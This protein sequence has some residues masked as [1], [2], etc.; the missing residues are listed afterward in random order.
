MDGSRPIDETLL[1]AQR[2]WMRRLARELV[3]DVHRAE[4]IVQETWRV[5]IERPPR[6]SQLPRLRRWL[7][8]VLLN[9]VRRERQ[10]DAAARWHE[11]RAG[12][13]VHSDAVDLDARLELEER[14][15]VAL[16]ALEE[17][18]REAVVLRYIDGLSV[19]QIARR[20]DVSR[21]NVRQR[22]SRG[23]AK[24]RERLDRSG[25]CGREWRSVWIGWLCGEPGTGTPVS[26]LEVTW[27]ASKTKVVVA[28]I[29]GL[30]A[31]SW[32]V[33]SPSEPSREQ[34]VTVASVVDGEALERKEPAPEREPAESLATRE[35][36]ELDTW[37]VDR[38]RD[39]HGVVIDGDGVPVA[40]AA[41]RVHRSYSSVPIVLRIWR[42]R[43]VQPILGTT[44]SDREGRFAIPLAAG[45]LHDLEAES[46]GFAR[47]WSL[48][49]QAGER[50]VIQL[51]EGATL[52]GRV[53]L[54]SDGT[55]VAGALVRIGP[56]DPY[57]A[58][59]RFAV[60]TART[61]ADGTFRLEALAPIPMA[62]SVETDAGAV[63]V[64]VSVKLRD[65]QVT[66]VEVPVQPGRSVRGRVTDAE[67]GLVIAGAEVAVQLPGM[68]EAVCRTAEDGTYSLEVVPTRAVVSIQGGRVPILRISSPGWITNERPLDLLP[69]DRP[70]ETIDIELERGY[71]L[72]GRI[73]DR[74]RNAVEDAEVTVATLA[75]RR[76][77]ALGIFQR[78]SVRSDA[79]G[80]FEVDGLRRDL[81]LHHSRQPEGNALH[82][83]AAGYAATVIELPLARKGEGLVD[84]GDIVL[85]SP[86]AVRGLVV[87]DRG[88]PI[89]GADVGVV[90]HGNDRQRA[91]SGDSPSPAVDSYFARYR[92]VADDLGRFTVMGLPPGEIVVT[93]RRL[94]IHRRT[95]E[96]ITLAEGE[97]RDGLRL[98]LPGG[99]S[100]RGSVQ[101]LDGEPVSGATVYIRGGG[102]GASVK[103]N[104]D[105]EFEGVGLLPGKYTVMAGLIPIAGQPRAYLNDG[106]KEISA[107]T[108]GV[109][110][111]LRQ[112]VEAAG[113][114]FGAGDAPMAST[115]MA[116]TSNEYWR[117][118]SCY[119]DS[120]GLFRVALPEG[121]SFD[122]VATSR[123]N[124]EVTELPLK[125]VVRGGEEDLVLR[126]Q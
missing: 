57:E 88:T 15:S 76:S 77:G 19:S 70:T 26:T 46:S 63:P 104:A 52:E 64:G 110:L 34:G 2:R 41:I 4:D 48:G 95:V 115:E 30:C 61:G 12:V 106:V 107:G 7:R 105:G 11:E 103:T 65:N 25:S 94:G 8:V 49:H 40:G 32:V 101:T 92:V 108:E 69:S 21:E 120:E 122:V 35:P 121:V 62:L 31:L 80:L 81:R 54:E 66:T 112:A 29:V 36:V 14:L 43:E 71:A 3:S 116:F 27:M 68:A 55:G 59:P 42:D 33:L 89:A 58:G 17:P 125:S 126:V 87:D 6:S 23:I 109:A 75:Y 85:S 16:R 60:A 56:Q 123:A 79:E 10:V 84:V 22:L 73:V 90:F 9:V 91:R 113:V 13:E 96:T 39:L 24:L 100:I 37:V 82:A 20:Q 47:Y 72:R 53:V 28:G 5:A 45:R 51:Q 44:E 93:A 117:D 83:V 67:T 1:L 98:V 74:A 118:I 86:G 38:E 124:G 99:E 102:G 50:V 111:V 97:T 114:L 78:W 18:Y 119:T